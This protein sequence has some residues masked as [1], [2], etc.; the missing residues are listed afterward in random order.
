MSFRKMA[1]AGC[2]AS[3]GALVLHGELRSWLQHIEATNPVEGLLYRTV[4]LPAGPVKSRRPPKE[5]VAALAQRQANAALYSLRAREAE[6]ALNFT[7]AED[8]WKRYADAA[9]DKVEGAEALAE[10]YGR[11]VE[12]D[13]EI[14]ALLRAAAVPSSPSD[15][16][17]A[18]NEQRQWRA[19]TRA[20]DVAR[21][22]QKPLD[23]ILERWMERYPN[24]ETAYLQAF[25]ARVDAGQ[26]AE[27][28]SIIAAYRTRFPNDPVFPISARASLEERRGGVSAAIAVYESAFQPLMPPEL[29]KQWF[30]AMGK[31]RKLREFLAGQRSSAA[32]RPT[33]L[34]PA[35]KLFYYWQQQRNL[36]QA[37][38]AL[39][40]FEQAKKAAN[41]PF[42]AQEL[43]VLARLFE[44]TH[45]YR[46]AARL[47][48]QLM[49]LNAA[50]V[51]DAERGMSGLIRVLLTAPEQPIR[52][53]A[54]DLSYWRDVATMDPY[55]GTANGILSL[56][57]NTTYP[58]SEFQQQERLSV[59]YFH[60]AEAARLVAEF[61]SRFPSSNER[62]SLRAK[63]IEAYATHGDNDGVI[64]RGKEYLQAFP[65]SPHRVEVGLAV[66]R[67]YARKNQINEE[68]AV[69]G[70]LLDELAAASGNVPLGSAATASNEPGSSDANDLPAHNMMRANQAARSPDYARVLDLYI[71]RLVS[72][73]RVRD[74]LAVYRAQIAKNPSD[75]GIY[76]RLATFLDQNKLATEL[77]Q[78]YAQAMR[79]FS[80]RSW[81]HKLARFYLRTKQT[82]QFTKLTRDITAT[83]SGTDLEQY[84]AQMGA[85][86]V[87]SKLYLQLNLYAHQRFPH[88][89]VF[90][91]NLLGAYSTKGTADAA[92]WESLLRQ[93]WYDAE[94]LRNRFFQH[95]SAT[96][97]LE[98][99]LKSLEA[100]A[101]PAH[102]DRAVEQFVA[103]GYAWR[104]YF[105]EAAPKFRTLAANYPAEETLAGRAA[106]LHRSLGD[107][108]NAIA[109]TERLI[110]AE[111][112]NT[113]T[114]ARA[115]E[116]WADRED[117]AKARP[118][119]NRISAVAPGDPAHALES[120]TVFWDYFLF[121]D[122]LRVIREARTRLK[123]PTLYAYEAGAILENKR[124]YPEAV[125]EYLAG[126]IAN[127]PNEA[128]RSRL[129][130]L[131]RMPRHRDL[132][133]SASRQLVAGS[134]PPLGAFNLRLAVLLNQG[135]ST[136]VESLLRNVVGRTN[137]WE[138]LARI[139]ETATN[140]GFDS[141]REASLNRQ[142]ALTGDPVEKMRLRITLARFYE[143]RKDA[144][145][146]GR[147]IDSLY[148]DHPRILGV[149]RAR[150]DY[151][152]RNKN[153]KEALQTLESAAAA[154]NPSYKKEFTLEAANKAT[155]AGE[156]ALARRVLQP[157]LEA[158]P[159]APEL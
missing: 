134:D 47:Y 85:Q 69:Y 73:K 143:S 10:Y 88:D 50:P 114:L 80:D 67:A 87:D 116:I 26:T 125:Q 33:D 107:I 105:E 132:V 122:A 95:L 31:A 99:E 2:I 156:Y 18:F 124:Q 135:R 89:L 136:E 93:H 106:S 138:V 6:Q 130:R 126:A 9:Q 7:Q 44:D 36:D 115:G 111:P 51:A 113:A 54:G 45:E 21:M 58:Q 8:D 34:T 23:P 65:K 157:Y 32:S 42:S 66:A 123:Q 20:V 149:V 19:L 52:I 48:A 97:K 151:Y 59:A 1:I 147:T 110:Q 71:S 12:P 108:P 15:E 16:T 86:G 74:A 78:T 133:E 158:D 56:L 61:D 60:R 81:A 94:D 43:S 25:Q 53:G 64:R 40:E 75:P 68:L 91:R 17:L 102:A 100:L 148:R 72:A 131:A 101:T 92:A 37:Q 153:W 104:G 154:S 29:V 159:L 155:T 79:Q 5:T 139:D 119:W 77:E 76:A 83:F 70:S 4:S 152:W 28:E 142:I 41:S 112:G 13:K 24:T 55:P 35:V 145:N 90:V 103:E 22:H 141:I 117:Y 109:I 140:Q 46:E 127:E 57:F 150:A 14:A 27:A 82:Q 11:R 120:A 39:L 3:L 128:A 84:F 118:F 129:I 30:D 96:G 49:K 121:D 144:A 98:A 38:R 137:S 146:A 63:L 62:A